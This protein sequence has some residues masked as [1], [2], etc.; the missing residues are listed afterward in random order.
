MTDESTSQAKTEAPT[1]RRLRDLRKKGQVAQSRDV[2]ATAVV[3]AGVAF[4]S[5]AGAWVLD[6]LNAIL[7]RAASA[8]FNALMDNAALLA[9]MHELFMQML[10][11]VL[12]L[13]AIAVASSVLFGFLQVGPVF[14]IEQVTPQL[15]RIDPVAGFKRIFSLRSLV[16][17][18][19]LLSKT[20][21]LVTV[22]AV[23]TWQALPALMQAHWLP[24]TGV[25]PLTFRVLS[26]LAWTAT[27]CFLLLTAFDVWF[28][29]W[30]YRRRNR[31]SIEE[32]R[33]EHREME[34]DPRLRA[35]RRQL[36]KEVNTASML[37]QVRTANVVIVNPT[38]IAV[39]LHYE[40]GKTDLP[41]VVAKGEGHL[42]QEIRRIAEREGIPIL[43]NVNL[44]RRLQSEAPLNQYIPDH[45]IEPVAA[46]LRWA[47]ELR[48]QV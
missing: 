31:M 39:A 40:A 2:S 45:F 14:S 21:V 47:R 15:A 1:A 3:I 6:G 11:L 38:H 42:A 44:A 48:R 24:L 17:L 10:R 43:H 41:V 4:L 22:C 20:L 37:E 29:T 34:G 16:E 26:L 13:V 7:Q 36:H 28:Q 12:P 9:W 30:D 46:V 23:L 25:L 19:K 5:I 27:I 35:R 18:L 8:D 33:R 32:V